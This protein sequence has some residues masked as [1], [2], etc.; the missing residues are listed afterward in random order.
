MKRKILLTAILSSLVGCA[1]Y[2]PEPHSTTELILPSDEKGKVCVNECKKIL[3]MEKQLANDEFVSSRISQGEYGRQSDIGMQ[4][5]NIMMAEHRYLECVV[6][7][8]GGR[9]EIKTVVY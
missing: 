4:N 3:L 6:N 8:C 5:I 2:V 7:N 1:T 9:T